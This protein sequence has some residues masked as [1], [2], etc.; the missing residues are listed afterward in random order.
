MKFSQMLY[1]RP[2]MR[3]IVTEGGA[4]VA[5]VKNAKSAADVMEQYEKFKAIAKNLHTLF[6]L[7]YIRHTIDTRDTFYDKENDFV[8]ENSPLV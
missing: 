1:T 8:D 2:D 6:A 4:L 7:V 3:Q 5:G